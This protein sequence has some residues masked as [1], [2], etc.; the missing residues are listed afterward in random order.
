M[1]LTLALALSLGLATPPATTQMVPPAPDFQSWSSEL[2]YLRV[3]RDVCRRKIAVLGLPLGIAGAA[4]AV[5]GSGGA[6]KSRLV[7]G[8]GGVD[9]AAFG[10]LVIVAGAGCSLSLSRRIEQ[11][12]AV[13]RAQNFA[14]P[15]WNSASWSSFLASQR[16]QQKS[17]VQAMAIGAGIAGVGGAMIAAHRPS[18]DEQGLKRLGPGSVPFIVGS[19]AVGYGAYMWVDSRLTI[20][21]LQ[22]Q[23]PAPKA[24]SFQI[25]PTGVRGTQAQFAV[26]F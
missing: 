22:R 18:S 7:M 25:V 23:R 6:S 10:G 13:G 5:K 20:G 19:L 26:S 21:A 1:T 9:A 4:M 15:R 3:A 17:A 14:A 11:L 16:A 12:E 8:A 24:I 2:L